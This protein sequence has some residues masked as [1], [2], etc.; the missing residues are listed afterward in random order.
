V[1]LP[2]IDGGLDLWQVVMSGMI[3]WTQEPLSETYTSLCYEQPLSLCGHS[4][5]YTY[6]PLVKEYTSEKLVFFYSCMEV[7][8]SCQRTT[9]FPSFWEFFFGMDIQH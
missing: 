8:L 3:L 2:S 6:R 4:P 9:N 1:G 5:V 7:Y